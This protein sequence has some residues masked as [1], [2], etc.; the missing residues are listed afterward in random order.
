M[1]SEL[2]RTLL[3]VEAHCSAGAGAFAIMEKPAVP[4]QE[5]AGFSI[6]LL[7]LDA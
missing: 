1:R 6:V 7:Q 4:H 5:F 2:G 3:P